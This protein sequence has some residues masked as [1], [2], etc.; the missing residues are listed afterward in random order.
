MTNPGRQPDADRYVYTTLPSCPKCAGRKV[1]A[2]R[3]K[4]EGDSVTR[5]RQCTACGHKFIEV[6]EWQS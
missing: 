4:H 6:A 3:T 5:Y 2:Y 1:N